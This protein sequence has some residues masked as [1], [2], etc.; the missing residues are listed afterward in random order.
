MMI[1][2]RSVEIGAAKGDA[3]GEGLPCLSVIQS[4][5]YAQKVSTPAKGVRHLD[6]G[7]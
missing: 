4:G 5:G 7:L 1:N 3:S 6:L 2:E